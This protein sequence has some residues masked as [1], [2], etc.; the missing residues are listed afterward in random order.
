M[1]LYK[2]NFL[3]SSD[4][5]VLQRC[6]ATAELVGVIH[7][8]LCNHEQGLVMRWKTRLKAYIDAGEPGI[9]GMLNFLNPVAVM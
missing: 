2:M 6:I 7:L 3:C 9:P 4:M 8:A 1:C 5:Q